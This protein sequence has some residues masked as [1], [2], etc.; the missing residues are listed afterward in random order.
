MTM[1]VKGIFR[2]LWEKGEDIGNG[3]RIRFFTQ[4]AKRGGI[5]VMHLHSNGELC[6]GA[7]PFSS[8]S[9][10]GWQVDQ[11]EPLTLSPSINAMGNDDNSSCLHGWIRNGRWESA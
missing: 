3:V 5:I 7:V 1:P 4:G 10:K 8:D 6:Q 2:D 9:T 11:E